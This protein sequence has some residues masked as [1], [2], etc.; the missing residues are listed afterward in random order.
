MF[1]WRDNYISYNGPAGAANDPYW[2]SVSLLLNYE[3]PQVMIADTAAPTRTWTLLNT[4][5]PT[6]NLRSPFASGGASLYFPNG[7]YV[8]TTTAFTQ[9]G[10]SN[11]TVEC[12][13]YLTGTLGS[14]QDIF[15]INGGFGDGY[16]QI[17]ISYTTSGAMYLLVSAVLGGWINTTTTAAGTVAANAWYHIAAVRNGN[18]FTLYVNGVSKL[19]YTSSLSLYA[20]YPGISTIGGAAS[21]QPAR[22]LTGFV[23]NFRY[24][25]GTAVY[26]SAFTPPT[27]PLTAITNTQSLI[28]FLNQG[29]PTT[30]ATLYNDQGPNAFTVTATGTPAWAGLTPFTNTYPGSIFYSGGANYLSMPANAAWNLSN[31]NWTFEC[32]INMT[33]LTAQGNYFPIVTWGTGG[34]ATFRIRSTGINF[35]GAPSFASAANFPSTMVINTWYHVAL[36]RSSSTTVTAYLNGVAGTPITTFTSGT[37]FGSAAAVMNI[38]Y[39]SDPQYFYGY[40]SN[41]RLVNGTAVYTSNFTPPTIPLTAITNTSGLI[42]GNTGSLYD[43]SNNGNR[44]A[45]EQATQTAV[46]KFGTQSGLTG[47]TSTS[48]TTVANATNLQFGT[49]DF[50]IEGWFYK[51]AI[52]DAKGMMGKGTNITGF[53]IR[54]NAS[55]QLVFATLNVNIKTSTT[56]ISAATWTYFAWTRTGSTNYM[57]INGVQEG[58]SVTDSYDFNQTENLTVGFV[59]NEAVWVGYLD[60]IRLTKGVCRYTSSFSPPSLPFPTS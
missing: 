32:W 13:I 18:I 14:N 40:M 29:Q 7:G 46:F 44:L 57:F 10:T 16:S 3:N 51:S 1:A 31:S 43:L 24:V 30:S 54:V 21:P 35:E 33:S 36:V 39:K 41:W 34:F 9:A 8:N 52:N 22:F 19:T 49:G 28:P 48:Y 38:G 37:T 59:S 11:W 58:A 2:T 42:S 45:T 12:W 25:L 23:S 56:T 60:D 27:S 5:L 53:R 17:R 4:P 50:T 15:N 26:T 6:P 55:N 20:S 47:T